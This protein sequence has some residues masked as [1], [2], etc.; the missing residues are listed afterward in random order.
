MIREFLSWVQDEVVFKMLEL[1]EKTPCSYYL[2]DLSI[3][4]LALLNDKLST[5][6]FEDEYGI[7][8]SNASDVLNFWEKYV[9]KLL[10]SHFNIN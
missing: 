7:P 2:L 10:I 4:V 5:H 9:C 1:E 6:Y 3:L 8:H